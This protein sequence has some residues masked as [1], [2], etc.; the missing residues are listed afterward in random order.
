[1]NFYLKGGF[2]VEFTAYE[3]EVMKERLT[4]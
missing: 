2:K 1:M 3:G 4:I